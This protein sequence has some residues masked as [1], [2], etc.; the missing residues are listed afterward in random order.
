VARPGSVRTTSFA[1]PQVALGHRPA[2]CFVAGSI[3]RRKTLTAAW[4]YG[5]APRGSRRCSG[6]RGPVTNLRVQL[7]G[8]ASARRTSHERVHSAI[9]R[10]STVD[11]QRRYLE[12]LSPR[13]VIHVAV[14]ER[15]EIVGLQIPDRCRV[16]SQW[17]IGPRRDFPRPL[18]RDEVS[19]ISFGPQRRLSLDTR[20]RC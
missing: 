10:A 12:S 11:Q 1:S 15:S 8:K 19:R 13:E 14:N 9:D 20:A 16:L 17:R 4:S 3:R 7:S 5:A 2:M 18:N 6:W